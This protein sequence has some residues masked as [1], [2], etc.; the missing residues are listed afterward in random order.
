MPLFNLNDSVK[1]VPVTPPSVTVPEIV[2]TASYYSTLTTSENIIGYLDG[3]PWLSTYYARYLGKD[4]TVI[5]FN[6]IVD[7]TLN[8]FLKINNFE[9]RLTSELTYTTNPETGT[10]TVSGEAN[11]Y[12]VIVPMVGD[13]FVAYISQTE[14]G[15]FQVSAFTRKSLYQQSSWT[16]AFQIIAY[17][18]SFN[19]NPYYDQ[20]VVNELFFDSTKL[21]IGNNPLFTKSEVLQLSEKEDITKNLINFYFLNF[22]DNTTKTF[23]VPSDSASYSNT[24]DPSVITFWNSIIDREM[25]YESGFSSPTE[26]AVTSSLITQPFVTIFDALLNHSKYTLNIAVKSMQSLSTGYFDVAYSR[27][28]VLVSNL[29]YIIYPY[30]NNGLADLTFGTSGTNTPYIFSLAFYN[31]VSGQTA[32]EQQVTNYLNKQIILFSNLQPIITTVFTDSKINNFYFIPIILALLQVC[33]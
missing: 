17:S 27:H 14:I 30:Y 4:D 28:T 24:Y 12:P 5:N 22:Y 8:Q 6:D 20:Y 2:D 25:Y 11:V 23:L 13:I 9:L 18:N 32:L 7:P 16:I 1:P 15:I 3:S 21:G 31:D 29:D 10:T 26:Y 19:N 33:K